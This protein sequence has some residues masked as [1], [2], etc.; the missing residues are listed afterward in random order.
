[1]KPVV[2]MDQCFREADGCRL[3]WINE[4]KGDAARFSAL[5]AEYIK[6]PEVT[7]RRI[8]LETLESVL[9]GIRS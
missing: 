7:R 8:C 4:A 2:T 9:P 1:M 6:A 5:L 3:K